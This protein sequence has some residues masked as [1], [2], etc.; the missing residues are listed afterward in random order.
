MLW[1]VAVADDPDALTR[2]LLSVLDN[3]LTVTPVAL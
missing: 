3:A 2:A 1:P